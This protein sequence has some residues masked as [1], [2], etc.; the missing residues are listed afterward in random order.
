MSRN[1]SPRDNAPPSFRGGYDAKTSRVIDRTHPAFGQSAAGAIL[2]MPCGRGS[3]SACPVLAEAIRL[4]NAPAAILP[5]ASDP[6]IAI[7]AIVA[8][9]LHGRAC[10]VAVCDVDGLGAIEAGA[11]IRIVV[12]DGQIAIALALQGAV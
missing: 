9:R 1:T 12:R 6:I 10:P 7:G 2:A 8:E 11:R 4:G 5:G 3:G